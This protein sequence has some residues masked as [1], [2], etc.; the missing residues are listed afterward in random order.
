MVGM[1]MNQML[2]NNHEQFKCILMLLFAKT[3]NKLLYLNLVNNIKATDAVDGYGKT[4]K[5]R[6]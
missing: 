4:Y 1:K 2:C 6:V 3:A 5:F